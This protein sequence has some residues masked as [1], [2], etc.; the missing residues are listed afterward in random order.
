[1]LDWSIWRKWHSPS[2]IMVVGSWWLWNLEEATLLISI[3]CNLILTSTLFP[4]Y[5]LIIYIQLI[6]YSSTKCPT[7][8]LL[9]IIIVYQTHCSHRCGIEDQR[10][11][12][13]VL[14]VSPDEEKFNNKFHSA[15]VL[16]EG[17]KLCQ[18]PVASTNS[19]SQWC[20]QANQTFAGD[21]LNAP[22]QV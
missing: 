18:N 14:W 3:S 19:D 13:L 5:S 10:C 16:D 9:N 15:P 7:F 17:N 2:Y 1:M 8:L 6:V 20:T 11:P 22:L 4:C 21:S 12:F